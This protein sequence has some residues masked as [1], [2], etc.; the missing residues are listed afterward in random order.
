MFFYIH[1]CTAITAIK[2]QNIFITKAIPCTHYQSHSALLAAPQ[3]PNYFLSLWMYL[4]W[5]FHA[6]VATQQVILGLGWLSLSRFRRASTLQQ[7]SAQHSYLGQNQ[8]R[9]VDGPHSVHPFVR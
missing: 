5:T 4:F 2:F 3:L 7:V 8:S 6:S 1:S 9:C